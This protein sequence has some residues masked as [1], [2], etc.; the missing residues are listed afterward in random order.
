MGT[1]VGDVTGGL[2][3]GYSLGDDKLVAAP[4]RCGGDLQV[5][6]FVGL[7]SIGSRSPRAEQSIRMASRFARVSSR[8]GLTTYHVAARR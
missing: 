2:S 6:L 4:V 8:F 1:D 7:V 5:C 3:R